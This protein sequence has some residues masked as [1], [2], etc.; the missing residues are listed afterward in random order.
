M[1]ID[2]SDWHAWQQY[3]KSTE[4]SLNN[5]GICYHNGL[6]EQLLQRF[7]TIVINI[8][9][10]DVVVDSILEFFYRKKQST[11]IQI[12]SYTLFVQLKHVPQ[13]L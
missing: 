13:N 7:C 1:P 10:V 5:F 11:N 8:I 6:V 2:P 3:S 12:Q 4:L 9:G